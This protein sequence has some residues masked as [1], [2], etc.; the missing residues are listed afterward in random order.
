MSFDEVKPR[1]EQ[2]VRAEK[3]SQ[4]YH[5]YVEALKSKAKIEIF[6]KQ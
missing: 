4:E 2:Q 3:M 5:K 1:I 6:V